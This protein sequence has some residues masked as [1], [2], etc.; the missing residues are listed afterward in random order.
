MEDIPYTSTQ[1]EDY[2]YNS[3]I[4]FCLFPTEMCVAPYQ[5]GYEGDANPMA[6]MHRNDY[7][8]CVQSYFLWQQQRG[9]IPVQLR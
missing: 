2:L 6:M 5:V 7:L 8:H 4:L 1:D 3:T 9:T